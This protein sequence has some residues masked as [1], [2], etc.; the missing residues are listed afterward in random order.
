LVPDGPPKK[1][2]SERN[3]RL[4]LVAAHNLRPSTDIRS[5]QPLEGAFH[6]RGL[7]LPNPSI[8]RGQ[9]RA[10]AENDAFPSD[11][12]CGKFG[13]FNKNMETDACHRLRGQYIASTLCALIDGKAMTW[14]RPM[15]SSMNGI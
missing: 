14:E 3:F 15:A 10:Y 5:N 11:S 13:I 4:S 6:H 7:P 8:V 2:H 12:H 1:L 9:V